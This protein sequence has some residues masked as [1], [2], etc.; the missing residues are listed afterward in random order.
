MSESFLPY[1]RQWIDDDD[2]DAVARVLKGDLLTGGPVTEAFEAALAAKVGATHAVAC[3]SG[4]AALH[5]AALALGLGPGDAVAVPAVTFLATANAARYVGAD[6][7]FIDV[8][9]D[10]ALMDVQDLEKKLASRPDVKAVFPVHMAGQA[11][12]MSA[13]RTLSRDRGIALVADAAHALGTIVNGQPVGADGHADMTVFSFHPV[14]T[15]CMGEGGAVTTADAELCERLVSLRNHGM[16]R[17]AGCFSQD[18]LARSADGDV[19]PWYYE[20][21]NVGYNYRAS[22]IH[23]ALGLSQ[24]AKLNHFVDKRRMLVTAYDAALAGLSPAVRPLGRRDGQ[25]PG[26]HLY[27]ALIDFNGLGVDRAVVMGR[28]RAIG[29]GTQ[30]HYIPVPWQPAYGGVKAKGDFT[31]AL[32]Y[33]SRCLSLP[34]YPAMTEQD[35]FRVVSALA[36]ALN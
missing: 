16:T 8:D 15:I 7:V 27:I 21:T 23:C 1:G 36:D 3:S 10:T 18:E 20:M 19:N 32:A 28:L 9:P 24:L 26:W 14:K 35:V 13:I 30:V 25:A 33:Y 5:L 4:T 31:G 22:E 2:V 34:L 11:A 12:D 17:D 29:I 6:V